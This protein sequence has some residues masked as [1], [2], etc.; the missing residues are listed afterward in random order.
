M[1]HLIDGSVSEDDTNIRVVQNAQSETRKMEKLVNKNKEYI[2]IRTVLMESRRAYKRILGGMEYAE[3]CE[4]ENL[5]LQEK[6]EMIKMVSK[7]F[8]DAEYFGSMVTKG[9]FAISGTENGYIDPKH[10]PH[11]HA[12]DVNKWKCTIGKKWLENEIMQNARRRLE[13][14]FH[15]RISKFSSTR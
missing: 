11:T 6:K 9:E 13:I 4:C 10:K 8:Q 7:A 15:K 12:E 14:G 2:R 3:M 5:N 1:A